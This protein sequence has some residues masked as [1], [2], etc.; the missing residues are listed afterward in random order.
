MDSEENSQQH[1]KAVR[2]NVF[3]PETFSPPWDS[4]PV[5]LLDFPLDF[6]YS[7]KEWNAIFETL[8]S[9]LAHPENWVRDRAID[10]LVY[11]L[12]VE[13]SQRS[14]CAD[15]QP[16]PTDQRI[17]SIFAAI[18]TQTLHTSNIFEVFCSK[19]K[20]LEKESLFHRLL[21]EWLNQLAASEDHDTLTQEAIVA[22]QLFLGAYDSTWQ[23]VGTTLLELLDHTDLNLRACAAYQIGKFCSKAVSRKDKG[24]DWDDEKD[25][26]DQQS[27]VG[28]PPINVLLSIIRTKELERPGVAGAFWSVIPKVG[29]DANE[30]LLNILENSPELEPDIPYFPC[31]LGFDAH[32][33]F[34][35]DPNA[36][37]RLI[38][39]GRVDIAIAAATDESCKIDA[40]EPLLIELGYDD[41]PEIVRLASWH[42]AYY[43]HYQHPR[44]A[45][46]EFIELISE[47]SEI[48][49]FLLFSEKKDTT[50]PYAVVIYPK[51][52]NQT[53][54]R[55]IAQK[56]IDQ[57]FP[58]AIRGKPREDLPF[59][60]SRWYQR[61]Y[62][63]YHLSTQNMESDSIDN[64]I[65]GY[66]S[67]LPWN[68]KQFL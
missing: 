23:A 52:T 62:V 41:D 66:R 42:L 59:I 45:E 6:P 43:Y 20:F 57:I 32:E 50:S 29:F 40:L 21:L 56:W 35:R 22:A 10:K 58:E 34:S 51:E 28:M 25:G 46:L 55:S 31:N 33:R 53:F 12:K 16:C 30:W 36:V 18:T 14:N 19:F 11:A 4:N 61:G 5:D 2:E 64:V 65:I 26:Q 60:A 17:K 44:G 24:W 48:D 9:L 38:D 15:Y 7:L 1:L 68:P 37:R 67:K 47:L 54:S 8:I 39:A 49:L 63:D 13:E 3:T 27:I